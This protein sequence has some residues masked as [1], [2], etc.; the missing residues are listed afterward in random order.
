MSSALVRYTAAR[1]NA[2]KSRNTRL[3]DGRVMKANRKE[4]SRSRESLIQLPR[5]NLRQGN[6]QDRHLAI[7]GCEIRNV[8]NVAAQL[9]GA[10]RV[11]LLP[12]TLFFIVIFCPHMAADTIQPS[13]YLAARHSCRASQRYEA[14]RKVPAMTELLDENLGSAPARPRLSRILD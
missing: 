5:F 12:T 7:F 11:D 4:F 6:I 14:V 8:I 13:G 10:S 1:E 9:A 2:T 3:I